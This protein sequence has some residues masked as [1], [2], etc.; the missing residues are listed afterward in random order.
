MNATFRTLV[1]AGVAAVAA[2]A[3]IGVRYANSPA[4][5]E[6]FSDVGDEFFADFKDPLKASELSVAKY[7]TD[8]KEA[9]SFSVKQNDAG[10]W[11]IPSHHDYPAEAAERLAKTAASLIGI[12]KVA[13]QSR[14][15]EDWARYGVEDP[16]AEASLSAGDKDGK[17]D[18]TRGTRIT[19]R[20]S[21]SN[22]LVD[23]IIGKAVEGREK[24][25]YVRQPEKNPVFIAKLDVALSAKFS[26]WIE[27]DLLKLNQND[28]TQVIVDRYSVDEEQG[29]IIQGEILEFSKDKTSNKWTMAGLDAAIESL[30]ETPITDLT[31]NLDQLKIVGVRPKP[32]G[33]NADLTVSREVAQNPLLRQI[34]QTDMQRQGFYIARGENDQVKLVSNEGELIAGTNN[35][36]RYTLYFGEIARGTAKDIETGL[37]EAKPAEGDAK[38]EGETDAD[39]ESPDAPKLEDG[40]ENAE[41]GPRRY[42]LV[43]V[44][45]D[46]SLLGE[47]PTEPVAPVK[48]AILSD[49]PTPA[50]PE[51]KS[52]KPEEKPATPEEKTGDAPEK[53]AKPADAP[54]DDAPPAEEPKPE[55]PKDEAPPAEESSDEPAKEAPESETPSEPTPEEPSDPGACDEP[56]PAENES[57]EPADESKPSEPE[58]PAEPVTEEPAAEKTEPTEPAPAKEGDPAPPADE[59]T[60]TDEPAPGE[61]KPDETKPADEPDAP[62]TQTPAEPPVDPKAEAQKQYNQAL[63]EYEAAKAGF[64]GALKAWE[65]RAKDGKKRAAELST[66]FGAWYY[67][68]SA[69]SFEKF[70]LSRES[71]VG[72]IE[73]EKPEDSAIPGAGSIPQFDLPG[74]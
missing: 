61:P 56:A 59:A 5:V 1:F 63:G 3:A 54:K 23:M 45:F 28:I 11:V 42:L 12:R 24:H 70:K 26:D 18:E 34:L 50:T 71:V 27:P 47:K 16:A 51:E 69:D 35:G 21:S 39:A 60:P 30:K 58:T 65:G 46:E 19:L 22:A 10:L 6:G 53:D 8:A 38:T 13:L 43:K 55:E 14:S 2:L 68:I 67:V 33:L 62:A 66:R 52:A 64:S 9:I 72:P 37:N 48:P 40:P 20:D 57:T 29:A 41:S 31:S 36:V 44:E 73:E 17:K 15:K 7:D 49:E 25:F 32:E 74:Q 4:A